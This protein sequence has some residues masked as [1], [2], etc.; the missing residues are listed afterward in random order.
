VTTPPKLDDLHA[1]VAVARAGS[2]TRAAAVLGGT[3]SALIRPLLCAHWKHDLA[4]R[5]TAAT[6]GFR[7]WTGS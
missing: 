1:F 3:S 7:S 5:P 6:S 2:F 4:A